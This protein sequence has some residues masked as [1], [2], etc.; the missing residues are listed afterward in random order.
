MIKLETSK[1]LLA[2][3][4]NVD[5]CNKPARLGAPAIVDPNKANV[6]IV[7][8]RNVVT[9]S[10][11]AVVFAAAYT[12]KGWR[13]LPAMTSLAGKKFYTD[14]EAETAVKAIFETVRDNSNSI[15][16]RKPPEKAHAPGH[17]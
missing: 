3:T 7:K 12:A 17:E 14:A 8:A 4:N 5:L 6:G 16:T 11:G 13:P 2:I 1:V 9:V 10:R 15:L